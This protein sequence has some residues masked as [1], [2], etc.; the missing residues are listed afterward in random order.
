[1]TPRHLSGAQKRKRGERLKEMS[2]KLPKLIRHYS[3]IEPE[4]THDRRDNDAKTQRKHL[5][6]AEVT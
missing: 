3:D 6:T 4:I 1:M 5:G 2:T